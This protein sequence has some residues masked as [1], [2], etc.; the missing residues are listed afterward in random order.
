MI[1]E[2]PRRQTHNGRS[3][4]MIVAPMT[5]R[6]RRRYERAALGQPEVRRFRRH[7]PIVAQQRID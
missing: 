6:E 7:S 2:C 3:I 1:F 4:E 5:L